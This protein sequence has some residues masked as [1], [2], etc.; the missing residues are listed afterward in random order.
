MHLTPGAAGST[1]SGGS[2]MKR[3]M[4]AGI[5]AITL[6]GTLAVAGSASAAAATDSGTGDPSGDRAAWVCE[7]HVSVEAELDHRLGE[8][9]HRIEWLTAQR[10]KAETAGRTKLVTRIDTALAKLNDRTA[11][12]QA[13]KDK[14]ATFV[15]DHCSVTG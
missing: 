13:R 4:W 1:K 6:V 9:Q 2:I 7:N 11:K 15:A 14:L 12:L 10:A 3:T 8:I 5:S